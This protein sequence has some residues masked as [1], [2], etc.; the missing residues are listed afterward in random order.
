MTWPFAT[1]SPAATDSCVT[2][3]PRWAWTSFSIFIASTMQSTWPAATSSPS[4]TATASTVPCI[5]ETTAS[6]TP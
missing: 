4:A 1:G 3:P 5:G 2:V 6:C